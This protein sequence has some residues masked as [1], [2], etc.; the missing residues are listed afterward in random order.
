MVK[1]KRPWAFGELKARLHRTER[2]EWN[3]LREQT[4]W[5]EQGKV[6]SMLIVGPHPEP[7]YM[8]GYEDGCH[9]T[10]FFIRELTAEV[11]KEIKELG[12]PVALC[13]S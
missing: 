6:L 10:T 8:V 1:A 5:Y 12:N 13:V 9:T 7:A 11:V 4:A 2:Q 3:E